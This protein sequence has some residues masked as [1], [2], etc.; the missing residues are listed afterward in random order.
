KPLAM[1][2]SRGVIRANDAS[3]FRQAFE[4]LRALCARADVLVERDPA[5]RGLLV[6]SFIP[7]REFAVE[8]LM[9]NGELRVLAIFDKPAPLDGPY[10][11]ES[12]YLTPSR[13]PAEVQAAIVRDVS[14]AASALGLRH[15]P[16]HAECRVNE[17]GVH[18]LEI[19][20]RPIGGLCSRA[21]RFI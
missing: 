2:G 7:G 21:L 1:S 14:V 3:E 11:E 6:E 4:R 12:I 9:T 5:H 13:E 8:G 18:M 10:F 16:V 19:A 17:R 15:G 20:G